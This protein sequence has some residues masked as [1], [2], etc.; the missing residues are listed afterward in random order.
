M[1]AITYPIPDGTK[2]NVTENGDGVDQHFILVHPSGNYVSDTEPFYT[3]DDG[4]G[5]AK[6]TIGKFLVESGGSSIDLAVDGSSTP[7]G[8][9]LRPGSEEIYRLCRL[10]LAIH[11]SAGGALTD[12]VKLGNLAALTNG[13]AIQT[14]NHNS[15]SVVTDWLDG[16]PIK[17][18]LDLL[19]HGFD[20]ANPANDVI[21]ATWDITRDGVSRRISGAGNQEFR[22]LVSDNLS[23][24]TRMTAWV[25]GWIE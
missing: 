6:S 22:I 5:R 21:I 19:E 15:S 8:Y 14:W 20:I 17:K 7:V 9:T 10:R 13:L 2:I 11:V 4:A 12:I 1:A 16:S 25:D 24:L 3:R 18:H 23:S